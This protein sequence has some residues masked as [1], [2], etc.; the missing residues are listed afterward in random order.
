MYGRWPN[1][2]AELLSIV[3]VVVVLL[4]QDYD[5]LKIGLPYLEVHMLSLATNRGESPENIWMR[6]GDSHM[7]LTMRYGFAVWGS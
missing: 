1:L 3:W 6:F 7:C 2:K 5:Q 4:L